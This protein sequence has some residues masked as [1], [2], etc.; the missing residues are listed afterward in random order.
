MSS[1]TT[2]LRRISNARGTNVLTDPVLG[3]RS[4]PTTTVEPN[5]WAIFVQRIESNGA[6]ISFCDTAHEIPGQVRKFLKD[7]SA[8]PCSVRYAPHAVF[9]TLPWTDKEQVCF[10]TGAW[11]HGDQV[12]V[13]HAA[14]AIADTGSLVLTSGPQSPTGLAFL[15]E[16]HIIAVARDQLVVSLSDAFATLPDKTRPNRHQNLPRTINIISGASR[17]ADIG[18]KIVHGAHGPRALCVII[19]GQA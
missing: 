10:Q 15:P 12:T 14:R 5:H 16:T 8:S 3:T 13:S 18:G 9:G 6:Q 1:R 11:Q 17:T 2:I 4:K 7:K 19:Y